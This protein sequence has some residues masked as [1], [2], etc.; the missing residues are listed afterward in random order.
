MTDAKTNAKPADDAG[1]VEMTNEQ[2]WA[3]IESEETGKGKDEDEGADEAP[4]PKDE[5]E[6]DD[7][8]SAPDDDD[9]SPSEDEDDADDADADTDGRNPDESLKDQLERLQHKFKSQKGRT[10][11]QQ[12]EIDQLKAQLASAPKAQTEKKGDDPQTTERREKLKAA[13][14]EYGDVIGPVVDTIKDLESRLESLSAK[15]AAKLDQSRSRYAELVAQEEAAF[16]SEH[17]DGFDVI[18]KNRKVFDDW[19]EDQPKALRDIY[20]ENMAEIT[21]GTKAA[22]LVS[23]FKSDLEDTG[24]T[25]AKTENEK[26]QSRR[27]RQLDGARSTRTTGRQDSSSRPPKDGA[28][29]EAHWAY[30]EARDKKRE[31]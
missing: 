14:E 29:P 15:D 12:R 16:T 22:Y 31:R 9:E 25:P 17:P 21:D 24:S 10:V 3:D 19:I 8:D 26:L 23:L 4:K 11:A 13:Q 30:F 2:L 18:V 1:E 20:R 27:Q 28:D 6:A 7:P 5:P